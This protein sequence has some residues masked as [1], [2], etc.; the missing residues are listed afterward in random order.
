M[1]GNSF[2]RVIAGSML[3]PMAG[4]LSRMRLG[5]VQWLILCAAAMVI[6]IM[7]LAFF[8]QGMTNLGWTVVSDIAPKKLIGLTGGLFNFT[9]N[10][11]GIVTGSDRVAA[12]P[13]NRVLFERGIPIAVQDGGQVQ[14]LRDVPDQSQW[15]IRSLLVQRQGSMT[16]VTAADTAH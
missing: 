6:A 3:R 8:G 1:P 9:T 2:E 4:A 10:L 12:L 11:A 5:V 13:R 14:Y 15:Q 16:R 7:S